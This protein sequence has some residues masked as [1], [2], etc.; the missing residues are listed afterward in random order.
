MLEIPTIHY[1]I[2]TSGCI[3]LSCGTLRERR[4]KALRAEVPVWL[5]IS[6]SRGYANVY[7]V[8]CT[9]HPPILTNNLSIDYSS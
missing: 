2:P 1:P 5:R 6:Y 9:K 7:S 8:R 3:R 4:G